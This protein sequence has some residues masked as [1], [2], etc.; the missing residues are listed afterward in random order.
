MVALPDEPMRVRVEISEPFDLV[1]G[2][3]EPVAVTGIISGEPLS[4][5]LA[6]QPGEPTSLAGREIR[7]I[8][9]RPYFAGH[10]LEDLFKGTSVTVR[11]TAYPH[12][13]IT[14]DFL[15]DAFPVT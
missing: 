3:D 12:V 10:S 8:A 7:W 11:G 2:S 5:R 4:E 1:A 13:Y 6:I 15:V 9:L 14:L